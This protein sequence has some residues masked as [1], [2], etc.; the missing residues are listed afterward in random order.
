MGAA[1]RRYGRDAGL[2]R[3]APVNQSEPWHRA[4]ARFQAA[5]V[6]FLTDEQFRRSVLDSS[7][8]CRP[9]AGLSGTEIERLRRMKQERVQLFSDCLFGN[10]MAAIE[11]AFPLSFKMMGA[12]MPALVRALDAQDVAVDTRKYAEAKRFADFVLT[13]ADQSAPPLPD[14]ALKML[15]YEFVML[16]LRVRPQ[17]PAWPGSAI[18][19]IEVF[20]QLLER[21]EDIGLALNRNHALVS[22]GGDIE[23]LQDLAPG[24][25]PVAKTDADVIILLH[26][27]DN[28]VVHRMCLNDASAAAVLMIER[29]GMFRSLIDAYAAWLGVTTTVGLEQEL[30]KLC[31]RLCDSGILR[32]EVLTDKSTRHAA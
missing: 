16:N 17:L 24:E 18:H 28:G 3:G 1:F 13:G 2:A 23:A 5:Y 6:R 14:A 8:I 22:V 20:H 32:F 29:T 31:A 19:S 30:K 26:R 4:E 11:E 9:P 25:G 27:G 10:R 15:N 7:E 21:G 12:A